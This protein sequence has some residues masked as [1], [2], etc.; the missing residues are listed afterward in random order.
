[1]LEEE[2]LDPVQGLQRALVLVVSGNLEGSG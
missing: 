1:M 2:L